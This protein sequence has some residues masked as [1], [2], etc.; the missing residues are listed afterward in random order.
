MK[1]EMRGLV[2]IIIFF[3]I[4]CITV[5]AWSLEDG[6]ENCKKWSFGA[7]D[8]QQDGTC[9][10]NQTWPIVTLKDSEAE[11]AVDSCKKFE[12]ATS[13]P[14]SLGKRTVYM[15]TSRGNPDSTQKS[16]L[17]HRMDKIYRGSTVEQDGVYYILGGDSITLYD[18]E[19]HR[20]KA[21][22]GKK[23]PGIRLRLDRISGLQWVAVVDRIKLRVAVNG[24][25]QS[26]PDIYSELVTINKGWVAIKWR[27]VIGTEQ[28][29]GQVQIW[30]DDKEVVD[31]MKIIK[32][33][34]SVR[35]SGQPIDTIVETTEFYNRAEYGITAAKRNDT[36]ELLMDN[37][38]MTVDGEGFSSRKQKRKQRLKKIFRRIKGRKCTRENPCTNMPYLERE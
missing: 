28:S 27:V 23:G 3:V 7:Q 5:D 8:G 16:H 18:V 19:C 32:Y 12:G 13:C 36:V 14:E 4:S 30:V 9:L 17:T 6:F 37:L 24:G 1:K 11:M 10:R 21:C 38:I 20:E 15:K 25:Y 29:N 26:L 35:Q 33:T 31:T 2:P 22:G 34:N